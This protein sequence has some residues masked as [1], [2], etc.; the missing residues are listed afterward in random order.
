MIFQLLVLA[1]SF[2]V[3]CLEHTERREGGERER[4]KGGGGG[5]EGEREGGR[6]EAKEGKRERERDTR[7][8]T[9]G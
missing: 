5:M 2:H 1:E 3:E 8:Q 4:E 9:N 6:G 7:I